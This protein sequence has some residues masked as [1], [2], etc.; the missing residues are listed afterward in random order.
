[1]F[2]WMESQMPETER[3]V[4][5][6]DESLNPIKLINAKIETEIK[7]WIIKH[8]DKINSDIENMLMTEFMILKE[9]LSIQSSP[10][11]L[12]D[13]VSPLY[14]MYKTLAMF[15][16][17]VLGFPPS[18]CF[19]LLVITNVSFPFIAQLK[20]EG[21]TR[22]ELTTMYVN[23]I[24]ENYVT[25]N[26]IY[27]RIKPFLNHVNDRV[28]HICNVVVPNKIKAD[29]MFIEDASKNKLSVTD[30]MRQYRPSQCHCE[31]LLGRIE[32]LLIEYFHESNGSFQYINNVKVGKEIGKGA[33]S[34]VQS[35]TGFVNNIDTLLAVKTLRAPL[36]DMYS[37]QQLSEARILR[38]FVTFSTIINVLKSYLLIK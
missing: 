19:S 30:I 3:S 29:R 7:A 10:F 20:C 11:G 4:S 9:D 37:Y 36:D 5:L 21:K 28:K 27:K 17:A 18:V 33:F 23:N 26:A 12:D 15:S 32:I 13:E 6:A 34:S 31:I 14:H 16:C 25:E 24:Y 38:Y 22:N 35:A 2:T 8:R 1:M